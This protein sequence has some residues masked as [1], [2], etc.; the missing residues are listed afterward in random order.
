MSYKA[1]SNL[2]EHVEIEAIKS[3]TPEEINALLNSA[4]E[5]I[6]KLQAENDNLRDSFREI[7]DL[8]YIDGLAIG[9]QKYFNIR[10]IC[11]DNMKKEKQDDQ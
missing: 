10:K 9:T 5:K 7:N 11:C 8:F 3:M 4:S 6:K 2:R 1:F